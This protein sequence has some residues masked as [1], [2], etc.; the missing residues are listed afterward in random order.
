MRKTNHGATMSP[1]MERLWDY[2]DKMK[3]GL[4]DWSTDNCVLRNWD[5]I[6]KAHDAAPS[7]EIKKDI[8]NIMRRKPCNRV[9][10]ANQAKVTSTTE[11]SSEALAGAVASDTDWWQ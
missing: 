9:T 1:R 5:K 4:S 3:S 11:D 10:K 2:L 8:A 7:E 6:V